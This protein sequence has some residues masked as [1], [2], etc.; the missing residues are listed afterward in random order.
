MGVSRA[1][2]GSV[3]APDG[4][5]FFFQVLP[6][7]FRD[8]VDDLDGYSLEPDLFL[9]VPYVPTD[10]AVVEA[11][12]DFAGVG[13]RDVIYD[14]GSGDGR[15]LVA[16]ALDRNARGVGV[17]LDP[18][19]VAD[20]MEYA[21]N[22]GAEFLVDFV[23]EDFFTADFSEA[24]VVTLYLLDSI[25][26]RLRPRLLDELRPGARIISHSFDMGDWAA[27]ER[28]ELNG[29]RLYKW[30]IPARVAGLWQWDGPDGTQ[31]RVNLQQKYQEVGGKVWI[32]GKEAVLTNVKLRGACLMLDVETNEKALSGSFMLHFAEDAL[33]S[34]S[35]REIDRG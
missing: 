7:L 27:D 13:P 20:A 29:T 8:L 10:D 6:P 25:N 16:A 12:L 4:P 3:Q 32:A 35:G 30:I 24:T 23:E 15:I 11:I 26:V 17:E 14:L 2:P 31:Y 33:Q 21:G 18:M 28:L 22:R 9:D 1:S 19:R 5:I 34:V